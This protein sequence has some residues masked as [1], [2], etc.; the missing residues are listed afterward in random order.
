MAEGGDGVVFPIGLGTAGLDQDVR[1]AEQKITSA[2]TRA[3]S[4]AQRVADSRPIKLP[5]LDTSSFDA[6]FSGMRAEIAGL[7]KKLKD[8][9]GG[10]IVRGGSG[11]PGGGVSPAGVSPY[12]VSGAP[13]LTPQTYHRP[14]YGDVIR[15]EGVGLPNPQTSLVSNSSGPSGGR[16]PGPGG[17]NPLPKGV[18]GFGS[19]DSGSGPYG[20]AGDTYVTA[21]AK[22]G[23]DEQ[24][25][26]NM[27]A[28]ALRVN[29]VGQGE[30]MTVNTVRN[31][32][33]DRLQGVQNY[34]AEERNRFSGTGGGP[35]WSAQKRDAEDRAGRKM[36]AAEFDRQQ[37][38]DRK[39]TGR[40]KG[41]GSGLGGFDE[42]RKGSGDVLKV[43]AGIEAAV[44]VTTVA[45]EGASLA[46][47]LWEG[48]TNKQQK[49]VEGVLG[50]IKE[51]PIF[52]ERI[53]AIGA[54]INDAFMGDASAAKAVADAA[55]NIEKSVDA[56]R[57]ATKLAEE[58][59][60]GFGRSAKEAARD[61]AQAFDR[62]PKKERNAIN[63]QRD[64]TVVAL[65]DQEKSAKE[66]LQKEADAERDP[67]EANLKEAMDRRDAAQKVMKRVPH[68]RGVNARGNLKTAEA[69]VVAASAA[70]QSV[71]KR[72]G[73]RA[74]ALA[75]S[76]NDA[77]TAENKRA[78]TEQAALM[79][80]TGQTRLAAMRESENRVVATA[81]EARTKELENEEK[82]L[83][84]RVTAVRA[85]GE[86]ERD[87]IGERA[88]EASLADP[89]NAPQIRRDASR[90]QVQ[91]ARATEAEVAAVVKAERER[92]VESLADSESNA[93]KSNLEAAG[94]DYAADLESFEAA[95]KAKIRAAK[96]T[97][98]RLAA[99]REKNAGRAAIDA[100]R[101][102]LAGDIEADA[103]GMELRRGGYDQQ[104]DT[105]AIS[106]EAEK[107]IRAAAGDT[108]TQDAIIARTREQLLSE[109][110]QTAKPIVISAS[111]AANTAFGGNT[112]PDNQL[113][114]INR[115]QLSELQR[116]AK[117]LAEPQPAQ[118][119]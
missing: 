90:E 60:K 106:R 17:N 8:A 27:E 36:S 9:S 114:E 49:A 2:L 22:R 116:I 16:G 64:D 50:A 97:E 21:R 56:G 86:R 113:T 37:E 95:A 104:A 115:K 62:G 71:D 23:K 39:G 3:A 30:D 38:S 7:E 29:R 24:Q 31:R 119:S 108:A 5:P 103:R 109:Q 118:T 43:I 44:A 88:E 92:L 87:A 53:V 40:G 12:G 85:A 66:Q 4:S 82:Y 32:M 14:T 79:D 89:E 69:D 70:V 63:N 57:R 11:A 98:E 1:A 101:A 96:T 59:M 91:A 47:A 65:R 52:G 33:T 83:E 111:E 42:L 41:R 54:K 28:M 100:E 25:L 67:L 74:A 117:L 75:K 99:E 81:A 61:T 15:V 68:M 26:R 6:V 94:H 10:R 19:P 93:R 34:N 84:A 77:V 55:A 45:I 80:R 112:R 110:N 72:S 13:I 48:D 20:V 102:E 107:E 18:S 78:A 58:A 35:G 51:I 76:A 46:T 73:E 105:E